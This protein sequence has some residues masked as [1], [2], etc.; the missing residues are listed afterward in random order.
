MPRLRPPRWPASPHRS[1]AARPLGAGSLLR[2]LLLRPLAAA[3][4]LPAVVLLA[5]APGHAQ[6]ATNEVEIWSATVTVHKDVEIRCGGDAT[7]IVYCDSEFDIDYSGDIGSMEPRTFVYGGTVFKVVYFS[8]I[9]LDWD[10]ESERILGTGSYILYVDSQPF[11]FEGPAERNYIFT[12]RGWPNVG[13]FRAGRT[14]SLRLVEVFESGLTLVL[15]DGSAAALTPAFSTAVTS[16]AAKVPQTADRVTVAASGTSVSISPADA[17]PGAPGHQVALAPGANAV[18]GAVTMGEGTAAATTTYTVT[19]TRA[20]TDVCERTAQARD[21]IVALVPD[22]TD[23]LDLTPAH[24]AA[25]TGVLD[26]QYQEISTLKPGDFGGLTGL[27]L[28]ILSGNSLTS[29]PHGIF[30]DLAAL[31]SLWL[32]FNPISA[33]PPRVFDNSTALTKLTM[34]GAHLTTLPPGVFDNLTALTSLILGSTL[35]ADPRSG[36]FDNLTALTFLNLSEARLTTLPPGVFE[37]LTVLTGLHVLANPGSA[38]FVPAA[39][40]GD[41]QTPPPGARVVLDGRASAESG[42]WKSNVAWAWNQV[43]AP[44][45]DVLDPPTVTLTGADTATLAF[46]APAAAGGL[47]FRLTVYGR[48]GDRVYYTATDTVTV[49]V[50]SSTAQM[51]ASLA[52]LA[53]THAGAP[54]ALSPAFSH[55]PDRYRA[56]P[57]NAAARVTVA[58][59]A[60]NAAATVAFLDLYGAPLSD[61]DRTTEDSFEVD[62]AEGGNVVR[63]QVTAPDGATSRTYVLSL[64]HNALP[65]GADRT[66]TI[67]EDTQHTF[68]TADFGFA[69]P[70]TGDALA[71]VTVATP[72]GAGRLS[73]DGADV[74]AG[75][76]VP[77]RDLDELTFTPAPDGHGNPYATFTFRVSDGTDES[78]A[79]STMTIVVTPLNDEATGAPDITGPSAHTAR[80][81]RR[82]GDGDAAPGARGSP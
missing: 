54:V 39:E 30:D 7:H 6:T 16:Y 20:A 24:L 44:Q 2:R 73:L 25:I 27:T 49:T 59:T 9:T 48:G 1:P 43:D 40:A 45:G 10:G 69:D 37:K 15:P 29:L 53:V 76:A 21:A 52:S 79:A 32:D 51:D 72:P 11:P 42:P 22:V 36:V 34:Q 23:C 5:P 14:L 12:D 62:L 17:D 81:A 19:V 55:G 35:L 56:R 41:A 38:G 82:G 18:T 77:A 66:V 64:S 47:H 74:G 78:A 26:L 13:A 3:L 8:N 28:L 75:D 33:I 71:G 57:A 4:L 58:A 31:E 63:V 65:A 70:D 50:A 68:G 80:C 67:A 61:A 60:G 46:T